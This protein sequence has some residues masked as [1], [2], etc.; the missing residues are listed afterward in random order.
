M[1]GIYLAISMTSR[2]NLKCFYCKPTGESISNKTGT[3]PAE[4]FKRIVAAAYR[5][6]IRKFRLT[7]GECTLVDYFGDAIQFI[8]DLG[9]DSRINIC[10]NGC[11]LEQYVDLIARYADRIHVRISVDSLS[12]YLNGF[13]FPKFL[14]TRTRELTKKLVSQGVETRF[15]IV[16]TSYNVQEVPAMIEES[17]KLGVN[18]KL[19][20][21]YI[22]DVYLGG[23][24]TSDAFWDSTYQSLTQFKPFLDKLCSSYKKEYWDDSAY[25]IPMGAYFY[26]KQSI[27]LKDS[28][29]GAHF[30]RFCVN[31]CSLFHKCQ[32]GIYVP[33][34][35]VG[36]VLHI[37][38][39]HNS[40]LRWY[41]KDMNEEQLDKAF[42]ELLALFQTLTVR[43][44]S[45]DKFRCHKTYSEDQ[46][47]I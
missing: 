8:M 10:S 2:C 47:D 28:S 19:L 24:G 32:E 36:D 11:G 41:L 12:E 35:S 39:C 3:I 17:L 45:S 22:Q 43:K 44:D 21:L 16:V 5:T 38:G 29:R 42:S 30:S 9:A 23:E 18:L 40:E 14:S 37:N 1:D 33:F 6:G 7:G 13:H 15:N 26:G 27:I 25:G 46:N 20:D 34:L 31:H 4:D